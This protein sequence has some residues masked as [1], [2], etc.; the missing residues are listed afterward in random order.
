MSCFPYLLILPPES[1]AH[2]RPIR[3]SLATWQLKNV[4]KYPTPATCTP[5]HVLPRFYNLQIPPD[6]P[7]W[8]SQTCSTESKRR[9][10]GSAT[11]DSPSVA[12]PPTTASSTPAPPTKSPSS[13]YPTSAKSTLSTQT[14]PLRA[15]SSPS[16]S[17]ARPKSS[18]RTRTAR[19]AS[20]RSPPAP[21]GTVSWRLSRRSRTGCTG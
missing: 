9:R 7:P 3:A 16:P 21:N 1:C 4:K 2:C 10:S 19:S 13:T 11:N 15:P 18:P 8:F 5:S 6:L 14:T 17:S 20:G 12:W